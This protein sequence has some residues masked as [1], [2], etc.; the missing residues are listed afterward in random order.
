MSRVESPML[1]LKGLMGNEIDRFLERNNNSF[2]PDLLD[3]SDNANRALLRRV[4]KKGYQAELIHMYV[5]KS[6]G[7]QDF[8][9]TNRPPSLFFEPKALTEVLSIHPYISVDHTQETLF[10]AWTFSLDPLRFSTTESLTLSRGRQFMNPIEPEPYLEVRFPARYEPTR[11]EVIFYP[12]IKESSRQTANISQ[13]EHELMKVL[14]LKEKRIP[15]ELDSQARRENWSF[16]P[17]RFYEVWE[18]IDKGH[19]FIVEVSLV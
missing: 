6:E 10:E 9:K 17:R 4:G 16:P 12:R 8:L 15:Q 7:L 14:G 3:F 18:K 2:S 5:R 19:S 11:P 13:L 1:P